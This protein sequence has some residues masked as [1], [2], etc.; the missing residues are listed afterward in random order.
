MQLVKFPRHRTAPYDIFHIFEHDHNLQ[1]AMIR[2]RTETSFMDRRAYRSPPGGWHSTAVVIGAPIWNA[3]R[4]PLMPFIFVPI[5]LQ[6]SH[7]RPI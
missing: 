4:L 3:L 7:Q 6:E 1:D 5:M 2:Q